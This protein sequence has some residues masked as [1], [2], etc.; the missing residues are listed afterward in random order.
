MNKQPFRLGT[1]DWGVRGCPCIRASKMP[2]GHKRV[3]A[4]GTSEAVTD[5]N[6]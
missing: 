6:I 1:G 4:T 5:P 2:R 3:K